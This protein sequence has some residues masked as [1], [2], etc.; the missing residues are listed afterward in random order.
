MIILVI[1]AVSG[2]AAVGV[3]VGYV[4]LLIIA[5]KSKAIISYP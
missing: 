5:I 2:C 3:G 4:P 1:S